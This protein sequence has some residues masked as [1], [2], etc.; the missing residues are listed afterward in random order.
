MKSLILLALFLTGC[1]SSN[2]SEEKAQPTELQDEVDLPFTVLHGDSNGNFMEREM[3]AFDNVTEY[4]GA[5][6]TVNKTRKPGVKAAEID[7]SKYT[8]AL[9]TMGKQ[10]TGGYTIKA[11]RV[12]RTDRNIIVYYS[13]RF[14]DPRSPVTMALTSPWTMIQFK[15]EKMPVIFVPLLN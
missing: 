14:P 15:N 3:I 2:V 13:E 8:V 4:E 6:S 1:G 10:N 11:E 9:L 5:L 7:F 12:E